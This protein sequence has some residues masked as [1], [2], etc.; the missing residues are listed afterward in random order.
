VARGPGR[1]VGRV[2]ETATHDERRD[3]EAEAFRT[4]R[5][6]AMMPIGPGRGGRSRGNG[7]GRHPWLG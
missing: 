1:V 5:T 4:G 7:R 6:L 2:S 3:L